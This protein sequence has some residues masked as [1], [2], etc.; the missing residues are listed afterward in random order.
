MGRKTLSIMEKLI[1]K[2]AD[3]DLWQCPDRKQ[4]PECCP[5]G[6][7]CFDEETGKIMMYRSIELEQQ[8][9]NGKI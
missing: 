7:M 9:I 1:I 2:K 4:H 3:I 5:Y 8:W 6:I